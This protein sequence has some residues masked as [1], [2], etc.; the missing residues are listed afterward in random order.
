MACT[1]EHRE[2]DSRDVITEGAH[3]VFWEKDGCW[4]VARPDKSRGDSF[5]WTDETYQTRAAAV[6]ALGA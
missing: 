5:Y 1:D 4:H 3:A 6:A 2:L